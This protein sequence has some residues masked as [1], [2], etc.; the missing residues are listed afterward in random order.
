MFCLLQTDI[1]ALYS[2]KGK[3][4]QLITTTYILFFLPSVLIIYFCWPTRPSYLLHL[5]I[6]CDSWHLSDVWTHF[7]LLHPTVA[8]NSKTVI[9]PV[10]HHTNSAFFPNLIGVF[11]L[12]HFTLLGPERGELRETD[13]SVYLSSCWT[14]QHFWTTFILDRLTAH[15]NDTSNWFWYNNVISCCSVISVKEVLLLSRYLV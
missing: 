8:M 1:K 6:I 9:L 14:N 5:L 11:S 10:T 7:T 3:Y 4:L 13:Y 2:V 12:S 15:S